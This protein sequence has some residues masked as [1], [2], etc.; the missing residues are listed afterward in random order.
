[1]SF[2]GFD[3]SL[4]ADD[5]PGPQEDIAVYTWGDDLAGQLIEGGDEAND[6]TFGEMPIGASFLLG[7]S[8][9]C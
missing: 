6:E 5:R 2:F 9:R 3:T 4:P 1:M 7:V 8:V